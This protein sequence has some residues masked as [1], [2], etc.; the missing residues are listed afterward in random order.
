MKKIQ[1]PPPDDFLKKQASPGKTCFRTAQSFSLIELLIVIAIIS[2]LASLLLPALNKAREH[3]QGIRCVGNL[4]QCITAVRLYSDDYADWFM[5]RRDANNLWRQELSGLRYLTETVAVCPSQPLVVKKEDPLYSRESY[6]VLYDFPGTSWGWDG[7]VSCD[8]TGDSPAYFLNFR[9]KKWKPAAP[10]LL[11]SL[12]CY[13]N[14]IQQWA[15]NSEQRNSAINATG[16]RPHN[17]HN[18]RT[19]TAMLDGHVEALTPQSYADY[20]VRGVSWQEMGISSMPRIYSFS[21]NFNLISVI[22][23]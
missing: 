8:V 21:Q 18:G 16:G 7:N 17:R 3:A 22:A 20:Y 9:S 19:N 12:R 23:K 6:A 4:K 2:I 15:Y 14:V 5:M 11:D 1:T 13:N 10:I